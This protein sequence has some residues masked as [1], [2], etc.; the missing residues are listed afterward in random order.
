MWFRPLK[1][2]R[3]PGWGSDGEMC[4][5]AAYC[6]WVEWG[7]DT[8]AARHAYIV[9]P[10]QSK[11][12]GPDAPHWY[13]LPIWARATATASAAPFPCG[14][15]GL[16]SGDADDRAAPPCRALSPACARARASAPA[17]AAPACTS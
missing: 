2:R 12:S 15:A 14:G 5:V 8:P 4:A 3:S 9:R 13:G 11:L 1:Y 17:R 7:N 6:A 10:E 16:E